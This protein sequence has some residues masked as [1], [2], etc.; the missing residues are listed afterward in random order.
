M[1]KA[2]LRVAVI[3]DFLEEQ[4]PSMDLVADMLV[5]HLARNH[6]AEVTVTKLRP[7]M[8]RLFS[9]L[10]TGTFFNA[11]RLLN[12]FF[13]YPRWLRTRRAE[14]DLFHVVDHTYAHLALQLPAERT[15]ITC[16]DLDAFR[17]LLESD[18]PGGHG[19]FRHFIRRILD[20]FQRAA[21]VICVSETTR[22]AI[23]RHGLVPCERTSVIYNGVHPF[24][25][26]PDSR[27]DTEAEA[28]LPSRQGREVYLLSVGS[29]IPR[30]RIDVLLRVFA[31]VRRQEPTVRLV[32][33]GGPFTASQDRLAKELGIGDAIVALPFLE[34][35]LLAAVYRKATVLLQTSE[36]EGFGLP[37]IEAMASGCPVAASDIPVFREVGGPVIT[38]CPVAD[39]DHWTSEVLRLLS[40]RNVSPEAW[41]ERQEA[42]ARW[43]SRFSWD[44]AARRTV[45]LYRQLIE[46]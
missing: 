20:G 2:P 36:T 39:I 3:C 43:A 12:R 38:L 10:G 28:L 4:W 25:S 32:R 17:P 22:E 5:A 1:S 46:A 7:S 26:Q 19:W 41:R 13:Y 44:E 18:A 11:D 14:F 40:E 45:D 35:K 33:V 9:R 16:H 24:L 34:I 27:S 15:L 30:K 23:V 6:A 8:L 29:T 21:R 31:A 37:L 42:S